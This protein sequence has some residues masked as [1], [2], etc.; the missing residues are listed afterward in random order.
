MH[1]RCLTQR[2]V[3]KGSYLMTAIQTRPPLLGGTLQRRG[4]AVS[5]LPG[6]PLLPAALLDMEQP[7]TVD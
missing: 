4:A 5:A 2:A 6:T 3:T 1:R 7:S